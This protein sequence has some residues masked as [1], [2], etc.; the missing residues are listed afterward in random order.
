MFGRICRLKDF[1]GP[2]IGSFLYEFVGYWFPFLFFGVIPLIL[3]PALN[4]FI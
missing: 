2:A 3:I 4:T 1:K